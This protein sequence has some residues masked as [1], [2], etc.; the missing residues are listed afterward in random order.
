MDDATGFTAQ[1]AATAADALRRATGAEPERFPLPQFVAMLSDEIRD[2]RE[3]GIGDEEISELLR[4]AG[5]TI[6]A[7]D[8][9]RY[10]VDTSNLK[11]ER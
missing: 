1:Q 4:D 8:I 7:P 5:V 9:T 3:R 2:L 11:R 10:Y 6:A